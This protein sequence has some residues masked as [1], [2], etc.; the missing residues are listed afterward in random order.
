MAAFEKGCNHGE[1]QQSLEAFAQKD[2]A[3]LE[4]DREI[5][6]DAPE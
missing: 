5:I 6:H 1:D 4:S 3:G 2:R